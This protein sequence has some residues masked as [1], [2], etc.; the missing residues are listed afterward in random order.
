MKITK[1]TKVNFTFVISVTTKFGMHPQQPG[2]NRTPANPLCH[3]ATTKPQS[4]MKKGRTESLT[5]EGGRRPTLRPS[6]LQGG[7]LP[8]TH[9][10]FSIPII[11]SLRLGNDRTGAI[12]KEEG[13]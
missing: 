10:P 6:R 4:K 1:I 7:L 2:G 11:R 3:L 13:S 8:L 5:L 9:F 12:H